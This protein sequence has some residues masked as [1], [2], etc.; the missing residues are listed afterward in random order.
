MH[1]KMAEAFTGV[2][3]RG[4]ERLQPM[5]SEVPF[6]P[7]ESAER[8]NPQDFHTKLNTARTWLADQS[9]GKDAAYVTRTLGV[10]QARRDVDAQSDRFDRVA[11]IF[12]RDRNFPPDAIRLAAIAEDMLQNVSSDREISDTDRLSDWIMRAAALEGKDT[13]EQRYAGDVKNRLLLLLRDEAI[14]RAKS[15]GVFNDLP[16]DDQTEKIHELENITGAWTDII[17]ARAITPEEAFEHMAYIKPAERRR[18]IAGTQVNE[19]DVPAQFGREVPDAFRPDDFNTV[20]NEL[21]AEIRNLNQDDNAYRELIQALTEV[22]KT[23]DTD[24][25]NVRDVQQYI[26]KLAGLTG[27]V[28][29]VPDLDKLRTE[30]MRTLRDMQNVQQQ[31]QER[32]QREQARAQ[33]HQQRE[34][35]KEAIQQHE[36]QRGLTS[37]NAQYYLTEEERMEIRLGGPEQWESFFN[38]RLA[39]LTAY[40]TALERIDPTI[41]AQLSALL[42]YVRTSGYLWFM[43]NKQLTERQAKDAAE[44]LLVSMTRDQVATIGAFSTVLQWRYAPDSES[45]IGA[46]RSINPDVLAHLTGYAFHDNEL[47]QRCFTSANRQTEMAITAFE[48]EKKRKHTRAKTREKQGLPISEEERQIL[49]DGPMLSVEDLFPH[50][51]DW[52]RVQRKQEQIDTWNLVKRFAQDHQLTQEEA[53]SA[54]RREWDRYARVAN[55]PQ[56]REILKQ[57]WGVRELIEEEVREYAIKT[58]LQRQ[59]DERGNRIPV[60]ERMTREQLAVF[61]AY[62]SQHPTSDDEEIITR[63]IENRSILLPVLQFTEEQGELYDEVKREMEKN[64]G[65]RV[66][67]IFF[68]TEDEQKIKT[69]RPLSPI[70]K[71][72]FEVMTQQEQQL[73]EKEAEEERRKGTF[74]D[75]EGAYAEKLEKR[76]KDAETK[77]REGYIRRGINAAVW[78]HIVTRRI[79]ALMTKHGDL[80]EGAERRLSGEGQA[81]RFDHW[82]YMWWSYF[83]FGDPA[84][85]DLEGVTFT[86]LAEHNLGKD[87]GIQN[88]K[89]WKTAL[90]KALEYR[91]KDEYKT[92]DALQ[93]FRDEVIEHLKKET[94]IPY[95]LFLIPSFVNVV[96]HYDYTGWRLQRMTLFPML[97]EMEKAGQLGNLDDDNQQE[98]A[99][100]VQFKEAGTL[101]DREVANGKNRFHN[102][103]LLLNEILHER[104]LADVSVSHPEAQKAKDYIL[105]LL[106]NKNNEDIKRINALLEQIRIHKNAT[107]GSKE[108]SDSA[109]MIKSIYGLDKFKKVKNELVVQRKKYLMKR[110]AN[111]LPLFVANL[112]PGETETMFSNLLI[113][114]NKTRQDVGA[115]RLDAMTNGQKTAFQGVYERVWGGFERAVMATQDDLVRNRVSKGETSNYFNT[116]FDAYLRNFL[117]E[118]YAS[119]GNACKSMAGNLRGYFTSMTEGNVGNAASLKKKGQI[120]EQEARLVGTRQFELITRIIRHT[121]ELSTMDWG[122]SSPDAWG[123]PD[124]WTRGINDMMTGLNVWKELNT[125]FTTFADVPLTQT[126]E[127]LKNAAASYAGYTDPDVA[128]SMSVPV[129]RAVVQEVKAPE[130]LEN[131]AP[132]LEGLVRWL[133]GKEGNLLGISQDNWNKVGLSLGASRIM[134]ILRDPNLPILQKNELRNVAEH[135]RRLNM[136]LHRPEVF[137]ELL[138]HLKIR[139]PDLKPAQ[140]RRVVWY[141]ALAI[142]SIMVVGGVAAATQAAKEGQS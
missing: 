113:G 61:N 65:K 123:A 42:D 109:A 44:A 29:S 14:R 104:D 5:T 40:P 105:S 28:Q 76:W 59:Q 142:A 92:P 96:G 23:I 18:V 119:Y 140:A 73:I 41:Q 118:D 95:E 90:E 63:L 12:P 81:Q 130:F 111:R 82:I 55:D 15:S 99:L 3:P 27:T 52:K 86:E 120:N 68:F 117:G 8:L 89:D 11:T 91:G 48:A 84:L 37:M 108:F 56:I 58:I 121:P 16:S 53:V 103:E 114:V 43:E 66:E 51:E 110:I 36:A 139:E 128:A 135:A 46:L 141:I 20:L 33:R 13:E 137:E 39:L 80:P 21:L 49:G 47:K 116:N 107:E 54:L 1:Q 97:N 88:E 71:W 134:E 72:P 69:K 79:N 32:I 9:R 34:S 75:T 67:E 83:H 112:L 22:V 115:D 35:R 62:K 87:L 127:H 45:A 129:F 25:F 60:E 50:I 19:I 122:S 57:K 102:L 106:P 98:F 78:H 17:N 124:A 125:F 138:A 24:A 38:D 132:E 26:R 31:I 100:G 6:V 93:G 64:P 136:F 94:G 30:T 101:N 7:Y 2:R 77:R 4:R 85:K 74:N 133:V 126:L 10:L 131:V 70:G